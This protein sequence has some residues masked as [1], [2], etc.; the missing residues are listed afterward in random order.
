M[1]GTAVVSGSV[2]LGGGPRCLYRDLIHVNYNDFV[3]E[4]HD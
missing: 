2:S 3:R 4:V 1:R